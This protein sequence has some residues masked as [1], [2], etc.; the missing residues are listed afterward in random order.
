EVFHAD[1]VILTAGAWIGELLKPLGIESNVY[2]QKGQILHVSL[3]ENETGNW[4]V[5]MLPTN[6]YILSF[7]DRFVL[8][9]TVESKAGFDLKTTAGGLHQIL[10]GVMD[11]AP[12]LEK[13]ILI[14]SRVGFRP[15]IPKSFNVIGA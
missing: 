5:A 7:D 6:K 13:S 3:P 8:G 10:S 12:E 2:P 15:A 14:E 1:Q 9:S 4:P 11:I